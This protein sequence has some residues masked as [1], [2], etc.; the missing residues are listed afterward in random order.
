MEKNQKI[1]IVDSFS[2]NNFHETFNSAFLLALTLS[3]KKKITYYA[4]NGAISAIKS[5]VRTHKLIDKLDGV[6]FSPL[7]IFEGNNSIGILLRY[8]LGFFINF[9]KLFFS[10]KGDMS[11]RQENTLII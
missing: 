10:S 1:I 3:S 2:I 8:I 6:S 9:N 4:S 5:L 11:K 7:K